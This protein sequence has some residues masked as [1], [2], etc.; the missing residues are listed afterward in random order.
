VDLVALGLALR[1]L[2]R[3]RGWRQSDL[4]RAAGVSQT[5][6]SAIERG[7][8]DRAAVRTLLRITAAL[9]AR[10]VMQLRW[11]GGDLERLLDA[12]HAALSARMAALLTG[13]DW[14]VR[15][16]VT[17]ATYRASGSID[18]LAWHPSTRTLLVIEV[19][20]E[21]TSAEGTL[22]KLDEKGRLAA[23]MA[24][25]RFGWDAAVVARLL[26]VEEASTARR[27]IEAHSAIFDAALPTAGRDIRR[28][29][30]GP[31]GSIA[32]RYFLSASTGTTGIQRRGG[33]H[34]V[35][36]SRRTVAQHRTSVAELDS[37]PDGRSED[38][39]PTI[40]VGYERPE[41]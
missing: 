11:R 4:A 13:L 6:I 22:R 12:D 9:D 2:R 15:V 8:G 29:L 17:Y 41:Y 40:L 36:A 25:E 37:K 34:R 3:R 14:Q 23:A 31:V 28:W 5:L 38:D 16:E 33:R 20:T 21:I 27:R 32:G 35:R 1:A 10:L 18:I 7:H 19:K 30:R 24:R 26:V 39:V